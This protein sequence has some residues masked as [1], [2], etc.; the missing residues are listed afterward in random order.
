M[1]WAKKQNGFTIVELLIVVVVIAILAAITV[2]AYNGIQNRAKDS[3]AQNAASQAGKKII[4]ASTL[5]A[6]LFP[7][8]ANLATE[9]GFAP[10]TDSS[11]EYQ[12]TVAVDQK[13]FCLTTTKN[14][15]SYYVS[16]TSLKPTT[17]ACP[18]HLANGVGEIITNLVANPSLEANANNWALHG[19]LTAGGRVQ[20]GGK[21]VFQGTRNNTSATAIYI[22]QTTP[23]AVAQNTDYTAS[24]LV[25]S[26]VTQQLNLQIRIGGTNTALTPNNLATVN[27]GVPTRLSV[28]SNTGSNST[29]F[30]TLLS[31]SGAV[32][33]L[34]T[35]DEAMLTVGTTLHP[36]ADG[37]TPG[38]LWTGATD[39]SASTGPA[40]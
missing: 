37:N 29:I 16:N 4:A 27:A 21:W 26:S 15:I 2:V 40:L 12:Y 35:V 38:W 6:D 36:Y 3:V 8:Y 23:I 32:S 7:T 18:G 22:S 31:A 30:I 9:T 25:T 13:S 20:V 11:A 34:W 24:L 39:L 5:N 33:D 14:K 28:T 17:G 1:L 19:G 10:G